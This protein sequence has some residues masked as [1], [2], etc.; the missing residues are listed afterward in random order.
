MRLQCFLYNYGIVLVYLYLFVRLI[1]IVTIF[2][3]LLI[4]TNDIL[5][6]KICIVNRF[7]L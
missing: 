5:I 1:K 2:I 3:K 6:S 7:I 4:F